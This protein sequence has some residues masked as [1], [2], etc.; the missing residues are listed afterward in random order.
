MKKALHLQYIYEV[1]Q[2]EV[3][4]KYAFNEYIIAHYPNE[5]DLFS[6]PENEQAY[7]FKLLDYV[8]D[9]AQKRRERSLES[10][11]K[12]LT[13]DED[14]KE[15]LA[16]FNMTEDKA[17][18]QIEEEEMRRELT[19]YETLL[20]SD[21]YVDRIRNLHIQLHGMSAIESEEIKAVQQMNDK[22][23][24]EEIVQLGLSNSTEVENEKSVK[25]EIR[26]YRESCINAM[27]QQEE[28]T[29]KERIKQ[30]KVNQAAKVI[31]NLAQQSVTIAAKHYDEKEYY[32][33]EAEIVEIE[34]GKENIDCEYLEAM[35]VTRDRLE[36][37]K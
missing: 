35:E 10:K 33:Y 17:I 4:N 6:L 3:L 26:A 2:I 25:K 22:Q 15:L 24:K 7:H 20:K 32:E 11:N 37:M 29:K 16:M 36:S 14:T 8:V 21:K 28:Q 18:A 12:N 23:M 19:P 1:F 34:Y 5:I 13:M 9:S 27:E 31:E 30:Q